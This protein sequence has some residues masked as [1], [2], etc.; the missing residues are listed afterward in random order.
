MTLRRMPYANRNRCDWCGCLLDMPPRLERQR[1]A[2]GRYGPQFFDHRVSRDMVRFVSAIDGNYVRA[3]LCPEHL[4]KFHNL[5][6][7]AS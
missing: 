7:A 5:T 3:R 6:E 4:A 1:T 2:D